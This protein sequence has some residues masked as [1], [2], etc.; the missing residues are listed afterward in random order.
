MKGGDASVLES[1]IKSS[2]GTVGSGQIFQVHLNKESFLDSWVYNVSLQ[3]KDNGDAFAVSKNG[4]SELLTENRADADRAIDAALAQLH[5]SSKKAEA[6][7]MYYIAACLSRMT[8]K[9]QNEEKCNRVVNAA[10]KYCEGGA[11]E[12]Y[13]QINAVATILNAMAYGLTPIRIPEGNWSVPAQKEPIDMPHFE[14]SEKLKLKAVA[15]LD[16]L[17]PGDHDRR[18][19]HRDMSLWYSQLGRDD[20]AL[21]EKQV[22]FKLVGVSDDRIMYP[23]AKG[24]GRLVWWTAGRANSA[25]LCGMG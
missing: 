24:C 7:Q 17:S 12:D 21:K 3:K 22:L 19:A 8:G 25:R 5:K 6:L 23:Q 16:R 2:I 20:K 4:H 1:H 11:G 18:K 14:Q 9:I 15:M 10:I 13:A